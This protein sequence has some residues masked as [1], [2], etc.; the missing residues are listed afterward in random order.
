M[1]LVPVKEA[2]SM[3]FQVPVLTQTNYPV[4]AVKVKAIMDANGVWETVEP[5]ALGAEPDEKKAKQALA[6]LF[7]AIPE[8]MVLQMAS[9]TDPKQVWD[10]LKTR[11][12]GVDRVRAARLATLRRELENMRMKEGEAVDD[13]VVK[14]NGIASK[15]RSLGYELE[16]IDLVKRLLDSI[17]KPFFQLVASIEQC[18]EL[19]TMLFDEAVGRLKAYEERLKAK[20]K[21]EDIQGGLLLVS[22]EKSHGCKH[23]GVGSSNR[24]D[25][26]RGRGRGRGSVR[27]RDGNERFR[28]KSHVKCYKCGEYGHY[29]NECPKLKNEEANL[30]EEEPALL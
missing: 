8:E 6:F 21:T 29:N 13:F 4:W 7:Q 22:H 15:V 1:A 20:E 19:E 12:L 16:E 5:R 25:F 28:D 27:G 26:R 30:I 24:D 2:G 3:S 14:L 9:Y 11:Y 10:G 18:F 23:C 17:P